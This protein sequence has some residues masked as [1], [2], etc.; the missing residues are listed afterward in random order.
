MTQ[1]T[2]ISQFWL[3]LSDP[4]YIITTAVS[5]AKRMLSVALCTYFQMS[6]NLCNITVNLNIIIYKTAGTLHRPYCV[7]GKVYDNIGTKENISVRS[8]K[9]F[10]SIYNFCIFRPHAIVLVLRIEFV[11]FRHCNQYYGWF[12]TIKDHSWSGSSWS[13]FKRRPLWLMVHA[14]K[15]TSITISHELLLKNVIPFNRF[16]GFRLAFNCL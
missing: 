1:W 7:G 6:F 15:Q 13:N 11:I 12:L 8:R 16:A 14:I 10:C 2:L 4:S 5:K 3:Q 9:T